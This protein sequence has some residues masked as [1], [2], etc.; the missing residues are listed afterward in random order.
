M[1]LILEIAAGIVLG[2]ASIAI[3]A[4]FRKQLLV[5]LML[6]PGLG[7]AAVGIV[8]L[9]CIC[10]SWGRVALAT[11]GLGITGAIIFLVNF[12]DSHENFGPSFRAMVST[13]AVAI[14]ILSFTSL[15][16]QAGNLMGSHAQLSLIILPGL[17]LSAFS[18]RFFYSYALRNELN[19]TREK[20]A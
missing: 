19:A 17:L 6:L 12:F 18:A 15:L 5:V 11:L 20:S 1:T 4:A 13:I 14:T 9:Y 16:I 2:L 8:V 3:I 10:G 7:G